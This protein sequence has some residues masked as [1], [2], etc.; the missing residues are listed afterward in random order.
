[1]ALIPAL[2]I[3]TAA[4]GAESISRPQ[5]QPHTLH[6]SPSMMNWRERRSIRHGEP[7]LGNKYTG[8]KTYCE[9][10]LSWPDHAGT[11]R[12]LIRPWTAKWP[13][14]QSLFFDSWKPFLL[15]MRPMPDPNSSNFQ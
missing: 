1:M 15:L 7:A 13:D 14:H 12:M 11:R 5:A 4:G 3:L 8:S 9:S 6:C 10:V 2:R